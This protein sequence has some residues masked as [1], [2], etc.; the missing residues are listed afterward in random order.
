MHASLSF[1]KQ[2]GGTDD[3]RFYIYKNGSLLPG[4]QVDIDVN[5]DASTAL[6]MVYGTL[7]SQNDYIE[8]WVE[9]PTGGDDMLVRD[10]QVVIRE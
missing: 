6:P 1:E 9:N 10:F 4:A 8:F 7:M 3:Y 5:D 2:G